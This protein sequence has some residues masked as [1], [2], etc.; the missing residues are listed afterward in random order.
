[1]SRPRCG[2]PGAP[3][4]D[5][6]LLPAPAA[7]RGGVGEA[8]PFRFA[9]IMS[10]VTRE[11]SNSEATANAA[12]HLLLDFA[13]SHSPAIFYVADLEGKR[14]VRFISSNV[15]S[16]TG[17]KAAAFL[18]EPG[19]GRRHIHPEDVAACDRSIGELRAHGQSTREYRFRSASGEYLWFRDELRRVPGGDEGEQFVGCMLDIT[20]RR[21]AETQLG[22]AEALNAAI[23]ETVQDAIVASDEAGAVIEFNPA[24]ERMFGYGRDEVM[25]RPLAELIVPERYRDAHLSGMQRFRE[26]GEARMMGRRVPIEARRADGSVF[27]VELSITRT[28]LC[29]RMVFVAEI[30]DI[31][32]R[33]AAKAERKRLNR[34]LQD[35][36]E[37]LA[38]G[39]AIADAEESVI[40][41]N[42]AFAEPYG[43]DA[44]AMIGT[45]RAANIRRLVPRLR[46][47][48]GVAVTGSDEDIERIVRRIGQ[49]EHGPIELEL[50]DGRWM[51]ITQS[52]T[53][54]GGHVMVRTDITRQKQAESALRE[55]EE[56]F[57]YIVENHPL[58]VFLFDMETGGVLYESPAVSTLLRRGASAG[59]PYSAVDYFP[60]IEA[61]REFV[62][63]LRGAGEVHDFEVRTRRHDGSLTWVSATARLIPYKDRDV[64]IASLVDLTERK[65]AEEA[66]RA[67]EERY[68][69]LVDNAPICIH[70]ID[71]EGRIR[72][73]NP[74]G[75][76]MAGAPK[77]SPVMGRPY[78][79]FVLAEDRER[80]AAQ[81]EAALA[82]KRVEFEF[83]GFNGRRYFYSTKIPVRG[84]TGEVERLIGI[85]LDIT[86]RKSQEA[87]LRRARETLQDAIESMPDGFA[88]WDA[89]D[90]LILCNS[91][92]REY[93]RM[94][95]DTLVPGVTWREFMRAG[96]ERGQYPEAQGI[97]ERWLTELR[98]ELDRHGMTREF[99]HAD[100]RWFRAMARRTRQGGLVGIRSDITPRKQM[101]EALRD[102]EALVRQVLE[103][104]PVPVLMTRIDGGIL[105][106]SPAGM[107]LFG[108]SPAEQ[109]D[110][111]ATN[112]W[113][114]A[115]DRDA[116]VAT[117]KERGSVEG[118][119]ARLKRKD[120]S[121]FPGSIS[122]R[123]IRF[124]GEEVIV[125]STYDLTERRTVEAQMVRQREALY[126][127]EKLSALGQL[128]A[129]VS[130]EL[131]NPLSV[132]VG[133]A[134]LLQ[135]TATDARIVGRARKIGNA[136]DRC[137]RIVKTFLAMARQQPA[138]MTCV[139]LNDIIETTLEVTGYALRSN[140]IDVQLG[141]AADLPAVWGDPDQLNQVLTNLIV[142]AQH[143]LED[144]EGVKRI[145]VATGYDPRS[146]RVY[147]KVRDNGPGI[148]KDIRSRIFEPFFTT[149]GE[150]SGTGIGLAVSHRIVASH[151]GSIRVESVPGQRT[152]FTVELPASDVPRAGQPVERRE[153][154]AAPGL[155]VLIV[156]DEHDVAE[157]IA[158]I[159][160]SDGH[161]V[162]VA[163]SG[164]QALKRL[165]GE[166]FDLILSDLRMP[167]LDGPSFHRVLQE[168][169]PALCA[170]VGFITGDT[171]G[172]KARQF[173]ESTTCPHLEKPVRPDELR[174]LVRRL[175]AH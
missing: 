157:V 78:L 123:L 24:A 33:V 100:G 45:R 95:A 2:A 172:P 170:R 11:S 126:Q 120:G 67:S 90:R 42:S 115:A 124:K 142:N 84:E 3:L 19:Y 72:T 112:Y 59:E 76:Q 80:V 41:C 65:E 137:A 119:E 1:M 99:R 88:L 173:L 130:H 6:A 153:A 171:L 81:L 66:L 97:G 12:Q 60:D 79:D 125:S 86:E 20:A 71:R 107:E 143:A 22:D 35:A 7:L 127:S 174:E 139:S 73:M 27:P 117:L 15:E 23:I 44:A 140:A 159:L 161:R 26:T 47:F 175:S 69:T 89:D 168:R 74:R 63:R 98:R 29:G 94:C 34:L 103:A 134:L 43:E 121:T 38:S 87:E 155:S 50:E 58:P 128:L 145:K 136:A 156:D 165:E 52:P 138:E 164:K 17:H 162:Q 105:Y 36:V 122:A 61:R 166:A 68:R 5:N 40:L 57:R 64:V 77:V 169:H 92:F 51:L 144:K 91:R 10:T 148:P 56:R 8:A 158:D 113:A 151:G 106:E 111:P 93:N 131:N 118:F 28:S 82:G 13:V 132:V 146:K 31:S 96:V 4:G 154:A 116:Y 163:H 135:E 55:S 48:D 39:F 62:H 150:G 46:R 102:S 32:D 167:E 14:P 30:T 37:S 114:D 85:A 101:E 133:Q 25:G 141:L 54:G 9:S 104:C 152:V 147:L 149:K 16:I 75:L 109:R 18:E 49:T 110:E 129:S 160:A 108:R 53:A 21:N 83:R 70:E